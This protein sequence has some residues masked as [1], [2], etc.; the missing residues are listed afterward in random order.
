[1]RNGSVS[2]TN[3][4]GAVIL[5]SDLY[6]L[7]LD[8]ARGGAITSCYS[9]Q[10]QREFCDPAAERLFNEY[11]GYFISQKQWRSSTENAARIQILQSGPLRAEVR[12]AVQVGG[13][14]YQTT[15]ALV[16]GQRRIDIQNRFTFA[17]DTWIG[18][19]WDI[20]PADRQKEPRRSSHDGRWK[21]Q[22]FFPA[23]LKN[24]AIYKN[25]AYDVCRSRNADTHFQRWDEIK[26]NLIVNWVDVV[27]EA[28]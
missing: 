24:Q 25:A 16:E 14:P 6:R 13:V 17:E 21:L 27:D 18:D 28:A 8:P 23:A 12:I 3:A 19:P 15:I 9:K 7:R 5:E 4:D 20:L 22:A 10:L 26:Q 11:R 2:A 1:A